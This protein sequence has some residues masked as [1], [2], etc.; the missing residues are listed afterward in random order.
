MYKYKDIKA[1]HLEM[2]ER[3]NLACLMCDRNINGGEVNP[4][5]EGRTLTYRDLRIAFPP[6]FVRQLKKIYMCGNYGDPI[7]APHVLEIMD[8]FRFHNKNINLG[9]ITNGCSKPKI[10]WNEIATV[11][12]YIRFGIDGL[13]DTHKMY[14]QK[15]IWDL[16]IRNA[17]A[18][19]DA[20]GYAIWDYLVFGHNEHQ[21]EEARALSKKLGFKEFVVKKTGRFFST[22]QLKG[23]DEH[24]G[25]TKPKTDSNIN[26]ALK[27]ESVILEKYGTMD[28]YLNQVEVDCK[29]LKGS[30]IYISAEGLVLPCCWLGGQLYKWFMKPGEAQI[31]QFINKDRISIY[32]NSIEDI[33]NGDT[34]KKIENSWSCK[35]VDEGRLKT[36]ALKC[37]KELD[38]FGEQ[39]K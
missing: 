2:T 27:K 33:I 16:V 22:A 12:D 8:Y 20:G 1:V 4:Y 21:I 34:F 26:Q 19:I 9:I 25:I 17:K 29:A 6:S 13:E 11:V 14:R 31:W 15:V 28:S 30:E 18:F 23:K 3:C 39:F 32:K 5:L 38:A 37:G 36:C 24:M 7:L 10:W 35:S